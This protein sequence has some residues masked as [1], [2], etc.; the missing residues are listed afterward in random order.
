M[1]FCS[2]LKWTERKR[3]RNVWGI[4]WPSLQ[5]HT[6]F[7][8]DRAH[9]E[10]LLQLDTKIV[11]TPGNLRSFPYRRYPFLTSDLDGDERSR[12]SRSDRSAFGNNFGTHWNGS[13]WYPGPLC[14]PCG[15]EKS[16]KSFFFVVIRFPDRPAHSS[17]TTA[18][19]SYLTPAGLQIGII[20]I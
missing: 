11:K 16:L 7:L 1:G 15:K 3:R 13:R 6:K 2:L 14:E 20:C 17:V 5:T 19:Y 18:T 8:Q 10:T 9:F 12:A 4:I